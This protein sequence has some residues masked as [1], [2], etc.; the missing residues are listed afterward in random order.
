[1]RESCRRT[2]GEY[3]SQPAPLGRQDRRADREYAA[4]DAVQPAGRHPAANGAGAEAQLA[5]LRQP[6]DPVLARRE[7]T[8]RQIAAGWT[9]FRLICRRF[10]VHPGRVAA[11]V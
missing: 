11:G 8:D 1:M 9:A 4:V 2:A 7:A 6:N 3:R 5:Q 10:V